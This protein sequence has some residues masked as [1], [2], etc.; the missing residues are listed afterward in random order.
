M[1]SYLAWLCRRSRCFSRSVEMMV[2]SLQLRFFLKVNGGSWAS[3]L[4]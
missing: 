4:S 2:Y 3:I 1:R